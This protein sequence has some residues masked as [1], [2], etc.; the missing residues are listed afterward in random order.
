MQEILPAKLDQSKFFEIFTTSTI[1]EVG[2]GH[3]AISDTSDVKQLKV[4]QDNRYYNTDFGYY[5]NRTLT[6]N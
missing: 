1:G 4:K 3:G 6:K 2:G 5:N